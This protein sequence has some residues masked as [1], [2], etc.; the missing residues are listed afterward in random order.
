MLM[1]FVHMHFYDLVPG[2]CYYSVVVTCV[3]DVGYLS[4]LWIVGIQ[5]QSIHA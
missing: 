5:L 2:G 3:P 4:L 1:L